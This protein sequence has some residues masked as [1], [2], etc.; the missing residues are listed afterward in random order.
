MIHMTDKETIAL[1]FLGR[2]VIPLKLGSTIQRA[3]TL[4]LETPEME[5]AE[6][7]GFVKEGV[8]KESLNAL[9]EGKTVLDIL[10]PLG[11]FSEYDLNVLEFGQQY[12]AIET[13]CEELLR[14]Y[15]L[16]HKS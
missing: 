9:D 4:T 15:T 13:A 8:I 6:K 11:I 3:L 7:Y 2:F 12:G 16:H 14:F 5:Y 10:A 1:A